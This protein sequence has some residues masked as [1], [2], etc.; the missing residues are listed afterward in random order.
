M[1]SQVGK[2]PKVFVGVSGGVDS[3]VALALLQKEGFDVTGVFLKTWYPDFQ[4]CDWKDERRSAMRVCATLGVPFITLDCEA[5]YK[6]EVVDYMIAEYKA[7]RTPN[8]D[9]F[10]N[11]YVK[12]GVFLKKALAMGADFVATGHYAQNIKRDTF[13]LHESVDDNKDQSY[14]LY[15]LNQEQL[16]HTLF[17]IGHMT[18]PEVRK[19]AEKFN[20]P[21]ATKKDSQGLCFIG[22]VDMKDFLAHFIEAKPGN[23]LNIKGEIVGVHDG[24]IFYTIGA[25]RGFTITKKSPDD[26]RFFVVAKDLEKNT[27]TVA[28]KELE[29]EVVYSI[30]EI[31]VP[32]MHFINGISPKE[33]FECEVRIRYR[34]QKQK[35]TVSKENDGY[36]IVFKEPLNGIALGQSAVLY[37]GTLCL[38]GGIIEKVK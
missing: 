34:Q 17:P 23:I 35:C 18:K 6:K 5:E 21:T 8:P 20:L 3:S 31:V 11:K 27:I 33:T 36:H 12:F 13:E 22:K 37:D 25:R 15:T 32:D 1:K 4:P 28:D 16:S 2:K 38:G 9:V 19:L 24:A 26:P 10:C 7:G 30:N 14:F 29:P